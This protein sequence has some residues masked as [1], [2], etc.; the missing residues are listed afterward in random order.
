MGDTELEAD[1]ERAWDEWASSEDA[2]LW[3]SAAADGLD[4]LAQA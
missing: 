4:G 3:E 1:Y 2:A